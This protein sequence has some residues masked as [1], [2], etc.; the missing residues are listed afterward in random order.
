MSA[1]LR[2]VQQQ[3]LAESL[4]A[5]LLQKVRWLNA[6]PENF[7]GLVLANE[8]LDALPVH[9]VSTSEN[10]TL[11][12]GVAFGEQGF[13]WSDRPLPDTLLQP[14]QAGLDL[15]PGY[16]TE[17]CPAAAGL[18]ASLSAMLEHGV[19]IFIDYGFPRREYYHPQRSQGTLMCHYRHYAH[20]N[21]FLYPGLQD[22]TAHVDFSAIAQTALQ[23]GLQ[24]KGYC[25]QAQFL[26]NCGI[27]ELLSRV[28]PHDMVAYAPLAAEAQKLLS[29]AEMGEIFKV[30]AFGKGCEH[31]LIGFA[32]GDK[33]HA[34]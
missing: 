5:T 15:P 26:I 20:D 12:R 11:E 33:S 23:N 8:V 17:L 30:I 27:T 4:P 32:S 31:P 18:V 16:L 6:L 29:P 1:H 14:M 25:T 19:A 3:R 21:P 7:K 9:L 13:V 28:S 10:R 34:L 24:L 22:I 2:E